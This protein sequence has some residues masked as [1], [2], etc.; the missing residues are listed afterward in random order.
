MAA[1]DFDPLYEA[2]EEWADERGVNDP[3]LREKLHG[4]LAAWLHEPRHEFISTD[5]PAMD[6]ADACAI[7]RWGCESEYPRR[8]M[9]TW[10]KR[11]ASVRVFKMADN[12]P[13]IAKLSPLQLAHKSVLENFSN[14]FFRNGSF[15]D[16]YVDNLSQ[17]HM[18]GEI[19]N[20]AE[21]CGKE[22]LFRLATAIGLDR[23]GYEDNLWNDREDY[24]GRIYEL[25]KRHEKRK[26]RGVIKCYL[27]AL[28]Q[29]ALKAMRRA[30]VRIAYL[31]E[32]LAGAS[33]GDSLFEY[34]PHKAV[35]PEAQKNRQKA[36][37][38]FPCLIHFM[39]GH[40]RLTKAIDCG[41]APL[42]T[43]A[44]YL[45][46]GRGQPISENLIHIV[47][48]LRGKKTRDID[49]EF[50]QG[51][52]Y[53]NAFYCHFESNLGF[54]SSL[55]R[56][57]W[58]SKP[59][60]WQAYE[61]LW[62]CA[63][64]WS[65][66]TG[67]TLAE[68]VRDI[69]RAAANMP[70]LKLPTRKGLSMPEYLA[71][72]GEFDTSKT[73][74]RDNGNLKDFFDLVAHQVCLPYVFQRAAELGHVWNPKISN[75]QQFSPL[76]QHYPEE[77]LRMIFRGVSVEKILRA[78]IK[79]HNNAARVQ[80]R[81]SRLS[82]L[83]D[84]EWG[85]LIDSLKTPDGVTVCCLTTTD[86]LRAEGDEMNHCVGGYSYQCFYQGL[87]VLSLKAG[88]GS[89][90]TTLDLAIDNHGVIYAPQHTGPHNR[91]INEQAQQ[92]ENWLVAE[93]NA[94]RLPINIAQINAFREEMERKRLENRCE[95]MLVKVGF[96]PFDAETSDN[97]YHTWRSTL[98]GIFPYKPSRVEY[99]HAIGLDKFVVE[100]V[101]K[102][103]ERTRPQLQCG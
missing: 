65:K 9:F 62:W 25:A 82:E 6:E 13:K 26:I 67:K 95:E 21:C 49:P 55:P 44:K 66:L 18:D 57:W 40:P 4:V 41:D 54:I 98:W 8:W 34:R 36:V 10:E 52:Y 76:K 30:R 64:D 87:H 51:I 24:G 27:K 81:T 35:L 83:S 2:L 43:L 56:D 33:D 29:D 88:D 89:W 80:Q 14:K 75:D 28:D 93:M 1:I 59:A 20:A 92:A 61:H 71:A 101:S 5:N 60:H 11:T 58:P 12:H 77:W 47:K 91:K 50:T 97:A 69:L 74:S 32:W 63:R 16:R 78:N 19:I 31:Y 73:I 48:H 86:E 99:L 46:Q 84:R 79:W 45:D 94:K 70:E 3:S 23:D 102:Y 90:R 17:N 85:A 53:Q 38:S 22:L 100:E 103:A 7:I 42:A 39:A 72:I 15:R 37:S 96:D 68:T